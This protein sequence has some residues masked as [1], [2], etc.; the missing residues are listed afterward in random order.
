M[1]KLLLIVLVLVVVLYVGA[2]FF[3]GSIVK[4]GVNAFGPK[5]TQTKVELAGA[6]ISPLTGSGTLTGLAVGNPKGWSERDA[7][8]LGKVHV[9]IRPLSLLG[10]HIVIEEI[11]VD[12]PEFLYETKIVSSNIKDL[13]KNIEEFSGGK[14]PEAKQP[15]AKDGKPIKFEIKKFRL[16]NGVARLGVGAAAVPVPL[17]PISIDNLGTKEGGITPDQAA[18]AIMRNVLGG[19]VSGTAEALSKTA[20]TIGANT[21]EQTK[22]AAKKAGEGIK[23]LFGGK[24]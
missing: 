4:A 21:V 11:T 15:V 5:L 8:K 23:K 6:S 12:G 10:D 1:K 17:P 24:P 22:D 16:T 13:L 14:N 2:T 18:G 3:L 20:G 7:F 19:I 9:A